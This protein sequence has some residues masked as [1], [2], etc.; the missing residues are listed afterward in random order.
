[1]KFYLMTDLEGVAGVYKWEDAEDES[2]MNYEE[3]CRQ[4]RWL[5]AEVNAAAEGLY[6]GG[7]AEVIVNDG[8]G[9]GYTLDLDCVDSRVEIIHGQQRPFWLPYL[10]ESCAATGIVGAH[11]KAGTAGANLCHTMNHS[12][13][14][15]WQFNG[16]SLGEMG[17]QAAIAGHYGVPMVLCTGDAWACREMAELIPGIVTVPVKHGTSRLSA[18]TCPLPEARRRIREGA[19]KAMKAIGNVEPLKLES[20]IHFREEQLGPA[21]DED[22]PPEGFRVIDSHVRETE[23]ED[24]L[25]L[26]GL[27]YRGYYDLNWK[28]LEFTPAWKK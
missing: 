16:I 4:R 24:I 18:L 3:R 6:E 19:E 10:D 8:H 7:A 27:I 15:D 5:T 13:I 14:R 28:P 17:L 21:F 2:L 23:A 9:A 26:V 12:T 20:P 11:A 22:S 1:M 25:Q